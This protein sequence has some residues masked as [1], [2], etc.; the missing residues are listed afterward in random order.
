MP[1]QH[2][3]IL[4]LYV[5]VS[6]HFNFQTRYLIPFKTKQNKTI[7]LYLTVP[8]VYLPHRYT[9]RLGSKVESSTPCLQS[10]IPCINKQRNCGPG[11]ESSFPC[12]PA[13][14][15]IFCIVSTM[16]IPSN[17]RSSSSEPAMSS[18]FCKS[19]T[20]VPAKQNQ[21]EHSAGLVPQYLQ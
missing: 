2:I 5:P 21:F 10:P 1:T 9:C 3:F 17:C 6:F 11:I 15:A 4:N 14:F 19:N 16:Q 7:S 20:L 12:Y 13:T 8:G 18:T